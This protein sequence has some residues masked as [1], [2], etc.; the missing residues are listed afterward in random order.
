MLSIAAAALFAGPG[1]ALA[2]SP[3]SSSPSSSSCAD[4]NE[5]PT[6]ISAGDFESSVL[7]LLNEERTSRGMGP[8]R[9]NGKLINAAA[10]HSASMRSGSY[11]SHT[12]PNG[13]TFAS[14]IQATGYTRQASRW[15]IGEN[16]A[17][18]SYQLG[19]P[20][21]LMTAWMNSAPHRENILQR[22]FRSIGVGVDWGS[23]NDPRAE[24]AIV[25]TDFGFVKRLKH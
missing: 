19:T 20:A 4:A 5:M 13:S 6:S 11:F 16:I 25:T 10:G 21:S 12:D 18:G 9:T 8:L 23:P 17:W 14:R 24:S 3:P 15:L 7:C 2:G 1:S 22:R